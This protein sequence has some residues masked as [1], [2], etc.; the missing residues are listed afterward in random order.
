MQSDYPS[1][2]ATRGN[3]IN[4]HIKSQI[5]SSVYPDPSS[6][7]ENILPIQRNAAAIAKSITYEVAYEVK[8]E[9]K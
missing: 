4:S 9:A 6:S 2:G 7:E 1:R 8:S 3:S 5:T